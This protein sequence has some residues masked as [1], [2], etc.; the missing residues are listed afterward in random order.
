MKVSAGFSISEA[1]LSFRFWSSDAK[2]MKQKDEKTRTLE[3]T[4]RIFGRFTQH[5]GA[6][7][8]PQA[9]AISKSLKKWGVQR[10]QS[11][12][13]QSGETKAEDLKEP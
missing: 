12:K 3:W 2:E 9:T 4:L 6:F 8:G 7:V 1:S 10:N 13:S 5:L 11:R